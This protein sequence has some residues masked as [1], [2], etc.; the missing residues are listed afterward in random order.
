MLLGDHVLDVE[1]EKIVV[2]FV[3]AA[4][5]TT[6]ACPISDKGP[7]RGI[8]HSRGQFPRSWRAFDLRMATK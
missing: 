4:V 5:L 2:V 6:A 1:G 3:E 7:E 8:H